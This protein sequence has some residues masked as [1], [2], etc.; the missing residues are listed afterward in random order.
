MLV[1]LSFMIRTEVCFMLLPFLLPFAGMARWCGESRF[2]RWRISGKYL[3]LIAAA[4]L[5]MAAV[6]SLDLLAYSGSEWSN[7]SQ[8]L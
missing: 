8:F 2:L 4:V 6:Y 1:V 7:F 5:C 3:T